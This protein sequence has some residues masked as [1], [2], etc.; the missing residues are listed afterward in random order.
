MARRTLVCVLLTA[1]TA[2]T[3]VRSVASDGEREWVAV[4]ACDG[5][6]WLTQSD[7]QNLLKR[8]GIASKLQGHRF[9]EVLVP[10]D[11]RDAAVSLIEGHRSLYATRFGEDRAPAVPAAPAA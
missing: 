4:A 3:S 11:S 8:R 5:G 7:L 1:V 2:T 6:D 10:V 9:F